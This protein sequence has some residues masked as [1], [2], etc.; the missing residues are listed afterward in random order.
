MERLD[1][2]KLFAYADELDGLAG[3]SSDRQRCTASCVTIQLGEHN[4][5]YAQ[6]LV[7]GGGCVN[8]VLTGHGVDNQHNFSGVHLSLDGLQLVH[9]SFVN[10]ETAC[11][12]Q[13]DYVIAVRVGMLDGCL[14][15]FNGIGLSHLENGDAQLSTDG[16]QLRD[17]SGTV[18]V[19]SYQQRSLALLFQVACQLCAVGGFTCTLQTNQ[20][21]NAGELGSDVDLLVFLAHESGKLFVDDLDDHLSRR[22]SLKHFLA[23]CALG[24]GLNK[25]L[26][27]LVANVSLQKSHANFA[28]CL[29]DVGLGQ[30]AFTTELFK[31]GIQFFG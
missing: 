20:H 4:A 15:N 3:S 18:N 19:T 7:K 14:G 24:N 16:F 11:G 27:D 1:H 8:S 23:A 31:G 12:I 26:N 30:S 21:N 28:H 22:Q 13:Q 6:C 29:L 5:G 10:V 2:V 25:V 17:C 9:K